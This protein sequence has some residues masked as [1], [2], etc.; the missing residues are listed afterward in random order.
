MAAP[1]TT[2]T[3]ALRR[4]VHTA[5]LHLHSGDDSYVLL[6]SKEL[7]LLLVSEHIFAF[8]IFIYCFIRFFESLISI[9]I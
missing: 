5:R 8:I 9:N 6:A 2:L 3:S 7:T 1:T 4:V